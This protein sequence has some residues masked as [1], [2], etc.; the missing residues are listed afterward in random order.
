VRRILSIG[1]MYP[2]HSEG[3]YEVA[4]RSNVRWLRDRGY[5][6]RVLTSDLRLEDRPGPEDPD[7][8]RDLRWYWQDYAFPPIGKLER[9]RLERDNAATLRR[10][11]DQHRPDVVTWWGMGGMSL[12]LIEQVRRAGLPAIGHVGDDWMVYG[13]EVDAWIRPWSSR[14]LLGRVAESV[15]GVP[16]RVEMGAAALWH[17]V[18]ESTRGKAARAWELPKTTITP[19][20][21]DAGLF[22]ALPEAEWGWR[23]LCAGRIDRRKGI[24]TAVR[25]LPLLPDE[26]VLEVVG[27]GDPDYSAEL[28][29]IADRLA[30]GDRLRL[31]GSQP[32]ERM[33][34]VYGRADAVLFPVRWEEPWGLVP[35]EAMA[36]GRPV[37]ATGTGG[38]G[39]Y[40]D[41]ER[42]CL[43]FPPDDAEALAASLRRLAEDAQ[44]RRRLRQG[45]LETAALHTEEAFNESLRRSIEEDLPAWSRDGPR[46]AP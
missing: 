3:G 8:H 27:D 12:S 19:A 37:L 38:S 43:A 36:V 30:V 23:L 44:L 31:A 17:F 10:H 5:A 34:E 28:R 18:S 41:H 45:G 24:D 14:P 26:A 1:S 9:L 16:T 29:R 39:E 22:A 40:L 11:L 7:V 42:N 46:G 35:L 13:P 21:I 32:H 15:S 25:V 2:P 4:W 33:A 6:V 20:G